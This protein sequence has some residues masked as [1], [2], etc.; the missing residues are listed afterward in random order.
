[1]L[2]HTLKQVY[3]T[4]QAKANRSPFL[5][6]LLI[7]L[8][9][10]L[11][12]LTL[13][14]DLP[15]VSEQLMGERFQTN[16]ALSGAILWLFFLTLLPIR[17]PAVRQLILALVFIPQIAQ[18]SYFAVY[19]DFISVF[20]LRFAGQDTLL[21][22]QL[23]IEN[24]PWLKVIALTLIELPLL[25]ILLQLPMKSRW[26]LRAPAA[27]FAFVLFGLASLNWYSTSKF[28]QSSVAYWA[29]FPSLIEHQNFTSEK[30][31]EKPQL[32]Y[33]QAH[34][35]APNIV[36]VIG[37]SLTES[38]MGLYGYERDT[39]PN[40]DQ[41][42]QQGRLLALK[43]AVSIGT[44]TISSVPHLLVGL[45]GIDPE[46][47]LFAM[48]SIFNYAKAA[49]YRTG[50]ITAQ[51]FKW[52]DV[53]QLFIDQDVNVYKNGSD[54]SA[55]VDILTGADD[56]AVLEKGILPFLKE[57]QQKPQPYL[58]VVQMNGSHYPYDLH[59][60]ESAK[61]FLPEES[62]N[63]LN[64]Y[65]N[66][67]SYTDEVLAALDKKLQQ[68]DP[69]AWIFYTSDHGQVV[70]KE[71]S[72]FNRGF[73]PNVINNAL[74]VM[75]SP[76]NLASVAANEHSPVSQADVFHTILGLMGSKTVTPATGLDL[77]NAIDP[78]RL[79]LVSRYTQVL[80]NDPFAALIL[81]D[82]SMIEVD[83]EKQSALDTDGETL[84]P[85][86]QLP[87]H[88]RDFVEGKTPNSNDLASSSN[89]SGN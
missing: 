10:L 57:A 84:I 63:S 42:E 9:I 55:D 62:R 89:L 74:L 7:S 27:F 14:R 32:D 39:T 61:R 59:S 70:H 13:V 25:M 75:S 34:D 4:L 52:R 6:T 49:G 71:K 88:Y 1:M 36:L 56:M 47:K 68:Q 29:V 3:A 87:Q 8:I 60:P 78:Q 15:W 19:Q 44:R 81:P 51:E 85:Y 24:T 72:R 65:D 16:F 58:L 5:A 23:G 73:H 66:T 30:L 76:Q 79:R 20:D 37:E 41:L 33:R 21:T 11:C 80:D 54:F 45:Q 2:T 82:R 46:G 28:Q 77:R 67:I 35:D 86:P 64:A 12:E 40:L 31:A 50:F 83:F 53:D 69:N 26:W 43:N 22:L 48:P 17:K 38:H 18:L